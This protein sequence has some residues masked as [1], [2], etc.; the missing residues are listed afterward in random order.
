MPKWAT[1]FEVL[2]NETE[3]F[4]LLTE[5]Q[6]TSIRKNKLFLPH[7]RMFSEIFQNIYMKI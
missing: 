7:L 4:S 6:E 2:I 1:N 3:I 5:I